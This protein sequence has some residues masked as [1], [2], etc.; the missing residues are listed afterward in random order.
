MV[1]YVLEQRWEV[2]LLPTYRRFPIWQKKEIIFSDEAHFDHGS[3]VN[4]QNCR[5]WGIESPHAYVENPTHPKRVTVWCGFWLRGI[6]GQFFFENEQDRYRDI[7]NENW[8][9]GYWQHL[10]SKRTAVRATQPKLHSIFCALFLKMG[11]SAAELMLFG[12]LGAAIWHRW[13]IICGVP[14]KIRLRRQARDNWRFK[15]QYSWN[16]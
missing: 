4:K 6:I 7:L 2:D 15:G 11:L 5:I 14:S 13:T 12:Q 8:R 1:V 9:G 3:Y 10:V 16:H